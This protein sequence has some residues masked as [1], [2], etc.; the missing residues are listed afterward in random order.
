[1]IRGL[2]TAALG[3]KTQQKRHDIILN[4]IA[5]V[6]TPGYK[7]DDAI[8]RTFPE[9]FQYRLGK[10]NQV[11]PHA[12]N[13][14]RAA[15]IHH[16]TLPRVGNLAQ[17]VTLEES[18]ISFKQ[19]Q[20]QFT[21]NPFDLAI[22][23]SNPATKA[24]YAVKEDLDSDEV[25]Y[26]RAGNMRLRELDGEYYLATQDGE[27]VMQRMANNELGPILITSEDFH[28]YEN[29]M[30]QVEDPGFAPIVG[31][32][33]VVQFTNEQLPGLIKTGHNIYAI[34]E[35]FLGAGFEPD[36]NQDSQIQQNFIEGSNVDIAQAVVDMM[37]AQRAYEA[38][39]RVVQT[40]DRNLDKAVNEI[41]RV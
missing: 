25:V 14:S 26:A 18:I 36:I 27:Y 2:Y 17:G 30:Y 1:M 34:D 33:H 15:T 32:I 13:T 35:T 31:E 19:G 12:P 11:H 39:Q 3:M 29:G 37:L 40:M 10:Y 20:L 22:V 8:I 24:F 21:E 23:D 7:A 41:G 9:E 4:N 16:M 5:N 6:E 38:N 28:V